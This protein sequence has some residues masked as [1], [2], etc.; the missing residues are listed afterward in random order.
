MRFGHRVAHSLGVSDGSRVVA[1]D[2]WGHPAVVPASTIDPLRSALDHRDHEGLRETFPGGARGYAKNYQ[3]SDD[4]RE[5]HRTLME[6]VLVRHEL[7]R[8]P[9]ECVS[10]A[11]AIVEQG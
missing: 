8:R 9:R 5:L 10:E 6:D 3:P 7:L 4:R 2:G 11:G 1:D